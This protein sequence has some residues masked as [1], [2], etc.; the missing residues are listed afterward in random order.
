MFD[1][2]QMSSKVLETVFYVLSIIKG[3][4]FL[5]SFTAF[6]LFVE[7]RTWYVFMLICFWS[8]PFLRNRI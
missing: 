6:I 8:S 7:F 2:D 4:G 3:E 1:K 5:Y